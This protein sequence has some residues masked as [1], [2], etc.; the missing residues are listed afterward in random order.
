MELTVIIKIDKNT[1]GTYAPL[2]AEAYQTLAVYDEVSGTWDESLIHAD[3]RHEDKS[4]HS[5]EEYFAHI[6]HLREKNLKFLM[7][8]IDEPDFVINANTRTITPQKIV[9]LEKDHMA[10]MIM[11]TIDRYFDYKDLNEATI[12]VQWTLPNGETGAAPI[13]V[14]DI[15]TTPGK[16]R[17]GWPLDD[18]ITSIPGTV[19]YS[20]RFWNKDGEDTEKQIVTYSL[21]TLSSNLT[22]T[23]ALQPEINDLNKVINPNKFFEKAVRNSQYS[24]DGTP[25]PLGPVFYKPATD[26]ESVYN[27]T[28]ANSIVLKAEAMTSDAGELSYSW[29]FAPATANE[30]LNLEAGKE[31]LLDDTKDAEGN[32]IEGIG[33]K[34]NC[35][36][37]YF[38]YE[39][40]DASVYELTT[41]PG[42]VKYYVEG[43]QGSHIAYA[44]IKPPALDE[45]GQPTTVLYRRYTTYTINSSDNQ[46]VGQYHVKATNTLG[47]NTTEPKSS[48]AATIPGPSDIVFT[49]KLANSAILTKAADAPEGTTETASLAVELAPDTNGTP[50]I[51]YEW[52]KNIEDKDNAEKW[53]PLEHNDKT[54]SVS[55]PGWYKVQV[56]ATLNRAVVESESENVCFVTFSPAEPTMTFGDYGTD[57]NP[58]D[59]DDYVTLNKS[60]GQ[61]VTLP[62]EATVAIDPDYSETYSDKLFSE[63]INYQWYMQ[64]LLSQTQK[65]VK[66]DDTNAIVVSGTQSNQLIIKPIKA[67]LYN[68][69][70]EA[71]NELNGQVSNPVSKTFYI[72]VT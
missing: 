54:L 35:E 36:I 15:E 13:E 69:R 34:L 57:A 20:V 18:S 41:L 55:I 44:S 23:K 42:N 58:D 4:F 6:G 19:Q 68:F 7:L 51:A 40:V 17:F 31:Y 45:S 70:C 8:P 62:V 26:L 64:D 3:C 67:G 50:T 16:I 11:F 21:N 2:W 65:E 12:Y 25:L 60:V 22:I 63:K 72:S 59:G 61:E 33:S 39:P 53:L 28:A 48:S 10:E 38:D 14:K 46:I 1:D 9:I 52:L 71:V 56:T 27:L 47:K 30:E 29:Y 24:G 37:D 66:L 49:T 43:K 5:M 32:V